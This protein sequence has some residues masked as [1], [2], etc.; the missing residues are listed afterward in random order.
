[1]KKSAEHFVEPIR[2]VLGSFEYA[3]LLHVGNSR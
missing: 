1:M 3:D 2:F